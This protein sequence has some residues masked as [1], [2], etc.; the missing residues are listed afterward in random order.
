MKGRIVQRRSE[1]VHPWRK[2]VV[3]VIIFT[4]LAMVS[5]DIYEI[6]WLL[7]ST[8]CQ[9]Q[10]PKRHNWIRRHSGGTPEVGKERTFTQ[11]S[12]A[13]KPHIYVK[14]RII[15][16]NRSSRFSKS[17]IRTTVV[18]LTQSDSEEDPKALP[19]PSHID[20]VVPFLASY[21]RHVLQQ[22]KR[23]EATSLYKTQPRGR[24]WLFAPRTFNKR[25]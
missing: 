10:S 15:R 24:I 23:I 5:F 4:P 11:F 1:L 25:F 18:L 6:Y 9:V 19:N 21:L 14:R 12:I 16:Y 8:D 7:C 13:T 2:F 17:R 22:S 20:G 3:I